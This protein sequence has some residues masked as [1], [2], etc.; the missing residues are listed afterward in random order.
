MFY[1]IFD[2]RYWN[3]FGGDQVFND[4]YEV[5]VIVG[6]YYLLQKLMMNC[7]LGNFFKMIICIEKQKFESWNVKVR[8]LRL[9]LDRLM[10]SMFEI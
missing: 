8:I 10:F 5:C 1:S 9:Y 7:I 6:Y 4:R 3:L 2:F